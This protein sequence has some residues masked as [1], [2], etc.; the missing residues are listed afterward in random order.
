MSS[1]TANTIAPL[2]INHSFEK[3]MLETF[4]DSEYLK[5]KKHN[6]H[7]HRA[8]IVKRGKVLAEA[9]NSVGSRS[10][11]A[12]FGDMTIHA[13]RAVVKKLGDISKLRGADL[14]V[15]RVGATEASRFSQPC[16]SCEQFLRK[17]MKEYG[18]RCVF[19]S[20]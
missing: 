5:Q 11:G 6:T 18:L 2:K 1:A 14:Y 12:G 20:I 17:C 16:H 4:C 8:V 19:Y 3:Y 13:E 7:L 10:M 15:F 9:T